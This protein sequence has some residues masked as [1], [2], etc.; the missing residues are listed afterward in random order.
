MLQETIAKMPTEEAMYH[1][2]RCIDSGL[3]VPE[4]GEAPP[5]EKT[6]TPAEN[7]NESPSK[8]FDVD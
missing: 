1:M 5:I 2:K 8:A 3:W 4:A 7:S 6:E